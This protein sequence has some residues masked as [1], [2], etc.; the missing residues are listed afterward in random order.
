MQAR[1]DPAYCGPILML[2]ARCDEVDEVVG[3]EVGADDYLTKTSASARV[4]GAESRPCCVG[5]ASR[6]RGRHKVR[7]LQ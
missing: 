7:R 5:L 4:A 2:T 3:L 6:F 1:C